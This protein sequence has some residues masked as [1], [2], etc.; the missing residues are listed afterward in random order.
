[1]AP[2]MICRGCG[3]EVPFLECL[4]DDSGAM[5]GTRHGG[6]CW[7]GRMPADWWNAPVVLTD[8]NKVKARRRGRNR[9]RNHQARLFEV[10]R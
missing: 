5:P 6:K 3:R 10:G 7:D 2:L 4:A 1:M 9:R 8:E